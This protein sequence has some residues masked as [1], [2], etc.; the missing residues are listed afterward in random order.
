[1]KIDDFSESTRKE[2]DENAKIKY[3]PAYKK[4]LIYAPGDSVQL[5]WN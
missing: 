4:S 5:S 2:S 1:M 3:L